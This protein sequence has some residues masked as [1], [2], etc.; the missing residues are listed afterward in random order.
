M[1]YRSQ[2]RYVDVATLWNYCNTLRGQIESLQ[3]QRS[4]RAI[5][6]LLILYFACHLLPDRSLS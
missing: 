4:F 2:G 5:L 1:S 3:V 6:D